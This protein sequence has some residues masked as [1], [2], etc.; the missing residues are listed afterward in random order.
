MSLKLMRGALLGASVLAMAGVA[1]AD[2]A[3]DS[4]LP[5]EFSANVGF[6]SDYRFRGISQT[7]TGAAIQGGFDYSYG[8]FYAGVWGSN[9]EFD[10]DGV[11]DSS[12]EMDIYLGITPSLGPIGFDIGGIYYAYPD[13]DDPDDGEYD[14]F[15]GYIGASTTLFEML[16]VGASANFSPEFFGETGEAIYTKGTVG[17]PLGPYFGLDGSIAWQTIDEADDYGDYSIGLTF[18][19]VGFDFDVRYIDTFGVDEALEDEDIFDETVV[20]SVG[21]SF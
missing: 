10:G 8:L 21:R 16:D 18:S 1:Y 19:L 9:V 20:F 17:I 2:E 13:A 15:E 14:F 5:G 12:I 11:G 7:D 4:V 3:A 6:T